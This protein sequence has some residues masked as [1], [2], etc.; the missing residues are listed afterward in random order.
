MQDIVGDTFSKE[1]VD[2]LASFAVELESKRGPLTRDAFAEG[3]D[4]LLSRHYTHA[5]MTT[6]RQH[7]DLLANS[8][9]EAVIDALS[10]KSKEIDKATV[11]SEIIQL[12]TRGAKNEEGFFRSIGVRGYAT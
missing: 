10:G 2:Q 12:G 1:Q 8:K 5:P 7:A 11:L 6:L 3:L 4:R 9:N